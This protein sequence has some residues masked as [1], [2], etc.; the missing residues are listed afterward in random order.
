MYIT[1]KLSK[2]MG[3]KLHNICLQCEVIHYSLHFDFRGSEAIAPRYL[4]SQ[5]NKPRRKALP[6]FYATKCSTQL[7]DKHL[8][9]VQLNFHE[10]DVFENFTVLLLAQLCN[11]HSNVTNEGHQSPSRKQKHPAFRKQF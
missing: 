7:P 5:A 4:S 10:S 1:T 11:F 3:R 9:Q 8:S 6:C 2:L